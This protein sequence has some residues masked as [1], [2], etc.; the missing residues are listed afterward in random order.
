[1]PLCTVDEVAVPPAH[2]AK[3]QQ[4]V[5]IDR[6][7]AVAEAIRARDPKAAARA[8]ALHFDDAIG[9]LLKAEASNGAD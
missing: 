8:M 2:A 3:S 6:H 1:V 5:M 4:E 9:D 7:R